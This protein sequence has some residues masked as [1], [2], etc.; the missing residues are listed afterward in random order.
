MRAPIGSP[1]PPGSNPAV[2]YDRRT[3]NRVIDAALYVERLRRNEVPARHKGTPPGGG[4]II[5]FVTATISAMSGGTAGQGSAVLATFN[6]STKALTQ[7]TG[8]A[9]TV[10]SYHE[11]TFVTGAIIAAFSW[12][13]VLWAFDVDK[14][15][16]YV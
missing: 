12:S 8:A 9:L 2:V 15:A 7:G 5:L 11:K 6:A 16:N 13:G 3:G 14:C 10:Y 1:K 4:P